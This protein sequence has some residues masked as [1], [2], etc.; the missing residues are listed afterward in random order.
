MK[1]GWQIHERV[2]AEEANPPGRRNRKVEGDRVD[3]NWQA[4]QGPKGEASSVLRKYA[5]GPS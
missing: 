1:Q 5:E 3:V 4:S 2:E